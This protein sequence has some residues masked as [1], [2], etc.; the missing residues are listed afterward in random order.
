MPI[1]PFPQRFLGR[2]IFIAGIVCVAAVNGLPITT[3]FDSISYIL[4]LFTRCLSFLSQ[5][6]IDYAASAAIAVI[7]LLLAG[8]PAAIYERARGLEQSTPFSLGI[9][10]AAACLLAL[11]A[12]ATLTAPP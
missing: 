2:N 5:G 12:L 7:T 3:F 9:W 11:R 6:A 4:Y 10:L 1:S 8:I